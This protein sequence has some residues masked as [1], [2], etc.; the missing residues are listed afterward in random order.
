MP[1]R[2]GFV[3]VSA[4]TLF[5]AGPG[6]SAAQQANPPP[7]WTWRLDGAQRVAT[8]QGVAPGEWRY[9]RMPPGWHVT[10]T[11]QGVVL[12]P[13]DRTVS[14]RWGIEAELFLFPNPGEAPLGLVLEAP[15]ARPAGSRQLRFLLRRDGTV[16]ATA[17]HGGRDSTLA[18]WKGDTAVKAHGGGVVKYVLRLMHEEGTLAFSVNGREMVA[19]PT[20]GEDP[21]AIPGLRIG[22]GLNVH[23]SRF[24]LITPLAPARPRPPSPTGR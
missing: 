15:D 17:H 10:T 14:G 13:N 18:P 12:F 11:E 20:G 7:D 5:A 23:V 8:G 1:A 6:T 24:D 9:E 2:V 3:V 19:L 21:R 22:P 4:A 16:G